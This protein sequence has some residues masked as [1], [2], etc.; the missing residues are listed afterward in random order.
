MSRSIIGGI[1]AIVI[2]ALTATAYF[3]TTSSLEGKLR[4]DAQRRVLRALGLLQRDSQLEGLAVQAKAEFFASEPSLLAAIRADNGG[5]RSR[6]SNRAFTRFREQQ[7]G[8]VPD[9]LAL[10]DASGDVIAMDG[11]PNPVPYAW[12]EGGSKTGN[13]IWPGVEL[14][15]RRRVS[16][17]EVWNYPY[18]GLMRVGIAPVIDPE[19][20]VP[21]GDEDGVIIVGAVVTAY[22][23]TSAEAQRQQM[24]LGADVAY[25]DGDRVFAT[26]FRRGN[27]EDTGTKNALTAILAKG[28]LGKPG[29]GVSVIALG[30]HE[31]FATSG[32]MSRFS[33]KELPEKYP[34]VSA[35]AIVLISPGL[36]PAS[37]TINTTRI[38]ILVLGLGSLAIALFGLHLLSRR[39]LVQVDS[40]E[41]GVAD[42]INGNLDRTFR[43]VGEE[44]DGLA[45]GLNVMLARLL[46]RP[47]PGEEEFDEN[48]NPIVPGR[49]EF[50]DADEG[51]KAPAPDPELAALAQEPEPD[52]YKRLFTEYVDARKKSGNPDEVSFESFIA[53]LKVNEGKLKAQ[54][55]SDRVRFRVVVKDGKVTLKP[56]PI[57]ST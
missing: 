48:G 42:I 32:R 7:E 52:Y 11:V 31:Y 15:L 38:L 50:E 5:D 51:G 55:N 22:A 24:L 44:L 46:G 27:E 39:F 13:G 3:V 36:E 35:G 33:S 25:F 49:V 20:Q 28:G 17:S 54:Y 23:L 10:V 4:S 16:I 2:A 57:F 19:A 26:S 18:K 8:P 21:S 29:T 6:E 56:V 34:P 53:K 12:K 30:G 45:N 41:L 43:P 37:D 1:V 14:A 40:I 9:I 47:E